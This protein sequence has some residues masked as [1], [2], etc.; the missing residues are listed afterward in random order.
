M[1]CQTTSPVISHHCM[2]L[3]LAGCGCGCIGREQTDGSL[4]SVRDHL[5][6]QLSSVEQQIQAAR[7]TKP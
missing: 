3:P 5:K 6:V 7:N 1:C 4:E 2:C